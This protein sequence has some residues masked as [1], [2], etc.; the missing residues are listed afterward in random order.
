MTISIRLTAVAVAVLL[1]AIAAGAEP[2]TSPG[3][4]TPPAAAAPLRWTVVERYPHDPRAFTQG[5]LVDGGTLYESTGLRGQSTVRVVDLTTGQ[6]RRKVEL[7]ADLFGEGLAK[8]G[9]RL[10]QLTWTE[11]RAR[12]YNL[13]DLSLA[14]EHRYEGQGWGLCFDGSRL[15]MSDGTHRLFFRNPESFAL[16]G[17]V[18]VFDGGRPVRHLNELECVRD[19]VYA[20]VWGTWDIVRIDPASGRVDGRIDATGLLSL[21][22]QESLSDGAVLNGIAHDPADDT[23]LLTGKL[24]PRV[25]RVRISDTQ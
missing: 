23:F 9:D 19:R 8:V 3:A 25:H 11:G 24:W 14:A 1:T 2:S 5:L 15:V 18:E 4:A 22:E 21:M 10:V 16:I 12:V 13:P 7:P 6:V 17:S 20:N